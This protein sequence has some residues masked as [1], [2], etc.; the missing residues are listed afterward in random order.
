VQPKPSI[1]LGPYQLFERIG[2]GG[3]GSVYRAAGPNGPVAVKILGATSEFDDAARARFEREIAALGQLAHGNL[4]AMLDHGVDAELGLYLVLPLLPGANLRGLCRQPVCPEAALLLAEPIAQATVALHGAGFV[5]RDLKPENTIAAPDGAVTVIDLGLAWREGMTR[6]TDTGAAVGSVGYMAPEQ[7]EGR[8]VDGA[9]DVWAIGVMIYEWIAG[10]RPFQRPRPSEEAGAV[11]LGACPRLTAADRRAGD[12]L[13]ELVASCLALDPA[14]RPSAVALRDAIVAM[15]DWTD[16]RSAER[17]AAV[18][19]PVGY[20]ARIAAFRVRRLE[21]LAREAIDAGKPFAALT[22]CDRGLAYLPDHP[23]L[24]ELVAIAEAAAAN[25]QS[26]QPAVAYAPTVTSE[27]MPRRRPRWPYV[28]AGVVAALA[29]AIYAVRRG[30]DGPAAAA[31]ASKDPWDSGKSNM[32]SSIFQPHVTVE[33]S[34][35]MDD[36]DRELVHDFVGVFGKA[37]DMKQNASAPPADTPTTAAGWLQLARTQTPADSIPSIR[38]ALALSP[39]WSDAQAALCVALAATGDAG[40]LDACDASVR[41]R[42]NDTAVRAGRAIARIQAGQPKAA[43]ADLDIVIAA[44]P[45]PKWRKLRAK[46]REATGDAAGAKR[47][48]DDACQLGSC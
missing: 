31:A 17:A 21:R 32:T 7:L 40:A 37:L 1:E 41:Q 36:R 23:P 30:D 4:V 18:A 33:R 43:L 9:A 20:Q 16:D 25:R 46:A 22:C 27:A 42:R 10:K 28:V 45:D 11:L 24:V 14:K 48:R 13:A 19:D 44:D 35:M 15:I 5:H 3:N 12:E 26:A 39:G 2:E 29:L 8:A 38:H 34:G 6:H 47:D